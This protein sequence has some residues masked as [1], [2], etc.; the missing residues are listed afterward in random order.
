[1]AVPAVADLG[2]AAIACCGR[3]NVIRKSVTIAGGDVN[4]DS[5]I[6]APYPASTPNAANAKSLALVGSSSTVAGSAG[7]LTFSSIDAAGNKTVVGVVPIASGA[8]F[9]NSIRNQIVNAIISKPGESLVVQ[10]SIA[11]TLYLAFVQ[12]DRIETLQFG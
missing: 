6:L 12:A 3:G 11:I 9:L 7:T 1:M 2:A 10:S 4:T 5:T 8:A